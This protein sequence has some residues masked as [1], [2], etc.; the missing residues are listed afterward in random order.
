MR[1]QIDGG[2]VECSLAGVDAH[3]FGRAL[4]PGDAIP[5]VLEV[6]SDEVLATFKDYYQG[7]IE[8]EAEDGLQ[9]E[10]RGDSLR[11]RETGYLSLER[12]IGEQPALLSNVLLREL[13][14]EFMGSLFVRRG[15]LDGKKYIL[16]TLTEVCIAEG[17]V[18]CK[19][20]AFLQPGFTTPR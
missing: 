19:G 13:P 16:Q 10:P 6:S 9:E 12:M 20:Q 18:V 1:C 7:F 17:V 15:S 3:L 11:L 4:T 8:G 5:Y 2:A 14:A